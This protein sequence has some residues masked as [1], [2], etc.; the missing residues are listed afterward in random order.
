MVD[1]TDAVH[2][3]GNLPFQKRGVQAKRDAPELYASG[4]GAYEM[5]KVAVVGGVGG[6]VGELSLLSKA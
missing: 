6:G 1:T 4:E 2:G 5:L 3:A